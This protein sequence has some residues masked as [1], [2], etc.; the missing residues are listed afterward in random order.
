[1]IL[2]NFSNLPMYIIPAQAEQNYKIAQCAVIIDER[3]KK[4][5]KIFDWIIKA[6]PDFVPIGRFP[7]LAMFWHNNPRQ[8]YMS[9]QNDHWN[10]C[11]RELCTLQLVE[12]SRKQLS[13]EAG[14]DLGYGQKSK[15]E[16]AGLGQGVITQM[17][18]DYLIFR[19]RLHFNNP[20]QV[21]YVDCKFWQGVHEPSCQKLAR[22]VDRAG[23][24]ATM[25]WA[26]HDDPEE[27]LAA[28]MQMVR[29]V[30][31]KPRRIPDN[32]VFL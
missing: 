22:I 10:L 14:P 28:A 17:A 25:A 13:C 12:P 23:V 30:P 15:L 5:G 2:N 6:R 1:M 29:E 19:D 7:P 31:A 3:E 32:A 21:I 16:F 18:V 9:W 11:P 8:V 24:N 27:H 4:R 26:Q 20:N